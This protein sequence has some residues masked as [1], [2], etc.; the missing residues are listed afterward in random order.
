MPMP[1]LREQ[2]CTLCGAD[3]QNVYRD[4]NRPS[5]V[6]ILC[7]ECRAFVSEKLGQTT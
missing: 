7:D 6:L 4:D 3:A 1:I 2:K 5:I